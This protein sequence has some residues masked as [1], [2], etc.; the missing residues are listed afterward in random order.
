MI[1]HSILLAATSA[2]VAGAVCI[3]ACGDDEPAS[4]ATAEV[5]QQ[6][7]EANEALAQASEQPVEGEP[8]PCALLTEAV[9]RRTFELAADTEITQRV[10][11]RPRRM[12]TYVWE[13]P[14]AEEIRAEIQKVQQERIREMM[15]KVRRGKVA[16]GLVGTIGMPTTTASV[17][18]NFGGPFES[19]EQARTAFDEG[20]RI[21]QQGTS[22]E[23][24]T[25][26]LRDTVTFQADHTA[27][28]GVADQAAWTPRINQ[29]SV[30]DG[31][32]VF[33]L[34][35]ELEVET[36]DNLDAAKRLAAALLAD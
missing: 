19:A 13:K 15:Q 30:L 6:L 27:V 7:E 31:A 9:I 28:A 20:L 4:T 11:E 17:H 5:E 29:L 12:C 24:K 35:V 1:R 23:V 25:K 21:L 26:N 33:H 14:N 34:S 10:M 18:L 3:H 16:D 8:D 32:T 36:D 22:R 2:A